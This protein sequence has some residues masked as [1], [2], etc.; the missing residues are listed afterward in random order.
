MDSCTCSLAFASSTPFSFICA[1]VILETVFRMCAGINVFWSSLCCVFSSSCGGVNDDDDAFAAII[2]FFFRFPTRLSVVVVV[3][4]WW[5]G[6]LWELWRLWTFF[7]TT[8]SM[9]GFAFFDQ[10]ADRTKPA[11]E[12][13]EEDIMCWC[14]ISKRVEYYDQKKDRSETKLLLDRTTV[15]PGGSKSVLETRI[16][17]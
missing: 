9:M 13:E 3:R 15:F 17:K 6:R 14:S 5:C 11:A 2:V 8:Q 1:S 16:I 7:P 12:E 4:W 10:V